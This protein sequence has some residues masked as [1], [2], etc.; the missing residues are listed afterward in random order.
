[1]LVGGDETERHRIVGRPF[2]VAAGK[3]PGGV[4]VDDQAQQQPG[5]VGRLTR[6]AV[7][8]G[9]RPQVQSLDYFRHE[10]CEVALR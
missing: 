10:P 6:A 7:A 1:M 3:H 9:H 4:T 8:A 2:Q 5:V